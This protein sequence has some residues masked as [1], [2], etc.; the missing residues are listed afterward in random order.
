[1]LNRKRSMPS[2]LN[3]KRSMS[4]MSKK[5]V[6]RDA[7]YVMAKPCGEECCIGRVGD[8]EL[9]E[10]AGLV[11]FPFPRGIAIDSAEEMAYQMAMKVPGADVETLQKVVLDFG[12]LGDWLRF[13]RDVPGADVER[14][15]RS[16]LVMGYV[17]GIFSYEP[18]LDPG[19]VIA[20][21]ERFVDEV[22]GADRE[23][24]DEGIERLKVN[25]DRYNFNLCL[26]RR[27]AMGKPDLIP[28][29]D[30]EYWSALVRGDGCC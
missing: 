2:M 23:L 18:M 15:Q 19:D 13:A 26:N 3:R 25:P 12:T 8:R 1:M 9:R 14:F 27:R 20:L 29:A 21:L 28:V 17:G 4:S 22:P 30:Y 7:G 5:A 16:A 6:L 10:R 11:S 24:I